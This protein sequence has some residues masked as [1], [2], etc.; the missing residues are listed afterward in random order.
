MVCGEQRTEILPPA[1]PTPTPEPSPSPVPL[2]SE[3]PKTN[4]PFSDVK[5]SAYFYDPVLWAFYHNPQIAIGTDSTHFSPHAV[6]TRAQV[7]TFLWR[8]MGQQMP[9]ST[10]NSFTDVKTSDYYYAAVLWAAEQ[11]ITMGTASDTFSPNT[12]CTRAH[13][14]TFLWRAEHKPEAATDNPFLDVAASQYYSDAVKWAVNQSPR[15]TEG[16]DALHFSPEEP[17]TRGQIVTF[18]Y[19]DLAD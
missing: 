19:R 13:V 6:C 11:G 1:T 5:T 3:E 2:P 15:I 9:K 7:V 14:I 10:A 16:T 12:P 4:H 8:A 18:L 17:C